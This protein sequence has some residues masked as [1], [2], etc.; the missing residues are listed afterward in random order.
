MHLRMKVL[1]TELQRQEPRAGAW[2]GEQTNN[3]IS[4][5]EG[6]TVACLPHY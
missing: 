5:Q 3:C 4:R 1:G 2:A 6:S